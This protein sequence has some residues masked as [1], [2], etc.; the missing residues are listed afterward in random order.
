MLSV[1]KAY[2]VCNLSEL[3]LITM[4]SVWKHIMFWFTQ[5][6]YAISMALC[7]MDSG[8]HIFCGEY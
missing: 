6:I 5:A 8:V 2:E 3:K 4:A 1:R 7:T